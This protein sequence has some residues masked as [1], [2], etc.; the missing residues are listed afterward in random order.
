MVSWPQ[1]AVVAPPPPFPDLFF[2][3]FC[4]FFKIIH[5]RLG[6]KRKNVSFYRGVCMCKG[7]TNNCQF[8]SPFFAPSPYTNLG[9]FQYNYGQLHHSLK[10]TNLHE[11]V[12]CLKVEEVI[13]RYVNTDAE[14]ETGIPC[15]RHNSHIKHK[16]G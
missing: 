14:V 8:F 10:S 4:A 16:K 7:K 2:W 11:V 3:R 13:V 5:V 15:D 9:C 12:N 6:K 1:G